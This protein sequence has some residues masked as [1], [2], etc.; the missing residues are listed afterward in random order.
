MKL[1]SVSYTQLLRMLERA[2]F[3]EEAKDEIDDG[4]E[5]PLGVTRREKVLMNKVS[6][7]KF[8]CAFFL[9]CLYVMGASN[10]SVLLDPPKA[11]QSKKTGQ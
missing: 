9:Q 8:S 2:G 5:K 7:G 4:T 3:V 11:H 10:V 1:R 6:R